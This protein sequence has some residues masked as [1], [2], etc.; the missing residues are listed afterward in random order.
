MCREKKNTL[1]LNSRLLYRFSLATNFPCIGV[2]FSVRVDVDVERRKRCQ[3]LNCA[4]ELSVQ[5]KIVF[6]DAAFV[7]V[8]VCSF[9]SF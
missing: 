4:L 7:L 9:C 5:L 6:F 8:K 3:P 1:A 2:W